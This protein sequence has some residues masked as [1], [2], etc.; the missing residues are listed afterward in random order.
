MSPNKLLLLADSPEEVVVYKPAGLH[1]HRTRLAHTEDSLQRQLRDQLGQWV[2]PV[3]RLDR[4]TAGLLLLALNADRARDLQQAFAAHRMQKSYLAVIRGWPTSDAGFCDRD[5]KE[6]DEKGQIHLKSALTA[7]RV[8]ARSER[9]HALGK[10]QCVRYALLLLQPQTGRRHQL[11]RHL[12]G[13]SHP[14]L[15]DRDHG[16]NRHNRLL[17]EH[18]GWRRL[19][20]VAVELA[21]P[22]ELGGSRYCCRPDEDF[23]Q[24]LK[25]LDLSAGFELLQ[26][27]GLLPEELPIVSRGAVPVARR[28]AAIRRRDFPNKR[29]CPLCHT[30]CGEYEESTRGLRYW[31]CDTCSLIFLDPLLRPDP[32]SETERYRLHHNDARDAGYRRFHRPLLNL[33]RPILDHLPQQS[34]ILDYGCGRDSALLAML[35]T[36]GL[37]AT[38]YDPVFYPELDVTQ[39]KWDLILCSEVVEHFHNVADEFARLSGLLAPGGHLAIQTQFYTDCTDFMAWWYRRDPTHVSFFSPTSIGW[40]AGKLG[41][42]VVYTD[43]HQLS[44]LQKP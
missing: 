11:R 25:A 38:G 36:M 37:Q 22:P 15:G 35:A 20:L 42:R 19:A 30:E 1:V 12:A 23:L 5:L 34:M 6:S 33:V 2:W 18:Y 44:L 21:L 40:L 14:I 8:L 4:A 39:G 7:W 41:L 3:H 16:D 28:K 27:E 32:L 31:K 26:R 13:L 10:H 24:L 29:T 43:E 17:A 9:P